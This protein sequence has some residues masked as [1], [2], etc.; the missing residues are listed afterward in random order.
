M[1]TTAVSVAGTTSAAIGRFLAPHVRQAGA[2]ALS[3]VAEQSQEKSERQL[4]VVSELASG[5][6]QALS[7][8]YCALEDSGKILAKNVAESTV[9][10]VTHR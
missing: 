7:T 1:L 8:I 9:D 2:R 3:H 4:A 10:V 5:G 6:V